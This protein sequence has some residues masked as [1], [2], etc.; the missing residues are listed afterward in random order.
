[1]VCLP[2]SNCLIS[3]LVTRLLGGLDEFL[4]DAWNQTITWLNIT[5]YWISQ[6]Y[7]HWHMYNL[8]VFNEV[9]AK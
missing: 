2:E 7:S 4:L 9:K 1:M 5:L 3:S 6:V 8:A